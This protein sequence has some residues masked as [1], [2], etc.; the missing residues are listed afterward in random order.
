MT[1]AF[2]R[3]KRIIAKL[4]SPEGCPWDRKQTHASLK[5]YLVEECY[6]VLQALDDGNPEKLQE[7]G[8]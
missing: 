6:E 3:L 2:V 1:E 8:H 7:E 4:R 5:P